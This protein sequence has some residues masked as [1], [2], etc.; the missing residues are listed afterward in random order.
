MTQSI[1]PADPGLPALR[2]LVAIADHG[3][4]G[5]AAREIGMAQSNASRALTGLERRLGLGLVRRSAA[6]SSL[7]P[8]GVLVV[9]W[10]RD[11]VDAMD[12]LTAGATAVRGGGTEV[13]VA[14]SMTIAEY[15]APA[16]LA[17]LRRARPGLAVTMQIMNSTGV[18]DAVRHGRADVGFIESPDVPDDVH[19]VAVGTD[20]LVVII[21]PDHPWAD[22]RGSVTVEEVAETALVE[23]EAG[24]GTRQFLDRAA[25]DHGIP[26]RIAPMAELTSNA[27]IVAAVAAGMGPAVLSIHAVR[28]ALV[29]GRVLGVPVVGGPI[30]RELRAMWIGGPT[31]PPAVAGLVEIASAAQEGPGAAR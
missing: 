7:T 20:R 17:A 24:S 23:R 22:R 13:G 27:A 1:D 19:S 14:A 21:A 29:D 30:E 11:V 8:E 6:G 16:W 31:P 18:V 2:L 10:A 12:R 25:A 5:A 15:L 9:G 28:G 3:A 4:L 26:R